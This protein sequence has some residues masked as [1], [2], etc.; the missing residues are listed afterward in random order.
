MKISL[1]LTAVA[2]AQ[3]KIDFFRLNYRLGKEGKEQKD[4]LALIHYID[5]DL[6]LNYSPLKLAV[7]L[8]ALLSQSAQQ[9]G[10]RLGAAFLEEMINQSWVLIEDKERQALLALNEPLPLT[11]WETEL[12]QQ[13]EIGN[14]QSLGELTQSVLWKSAKGQLYLHTLACAVLQ[15][16]ASTCAHAQFNLT[17]I[18]I[19]LLQQ[20]RED[21]YEAAINLLKPYTISVNEETHRILKQ[22]QVEQSHQLLASYHLSEIYRLV[23]QQNRK[24]K[25]SER[26]A[27]EAQWK[28]NYQYLKRSGIWRVLGAQLEYRLSTRQQ[29]FLFYFYQDAND[30]LPLEMIT[31]SKRGHSMKQDKAIPPY[32]RKRKGSWL[33]VLAAGAMTGVFG[34]ALYLV[35]TSIL[36]QAFTVMLLV[37]LVL[38]ASLALASAGMLIFSLSYCIKDIIKARQIRQEHT[39]AGLVF[40]DKPVDGLTPL[41]ADL[42]THQAPQHSS[43]ARSG[44][45]AKAATIKATETRKSA[46]ANNPQQTLGL[47]QFL[48]RFGWQSSKSSQSAK[49]NTH[50]NTPAI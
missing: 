16:R 6:Q 27:L 14:Q 34:I 1:Q 10:C 47:G 39:E 45:M 7:L 36:A 23:L 18:Q 22:T 43:V 15:Q 19:R 4:I 38:V 26:Q 11:T 24:L 49:A 46:S 2:W 8:Q 32:T 20:L 5:N 40:K 12:I 31:D 44:A 37:P 33:A 17:L 41:E 13:L 9:N 42:Q 30:L 50:T 28:E 48:N 35:I 25:P 29:S 21:W 3:L